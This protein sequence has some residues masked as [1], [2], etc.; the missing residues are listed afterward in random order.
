MGFVAPGRRA[1]KG[2]SFRVFE[3]AL[4]TMARCAYCKTP[5]GHLKDTEACAGCGAPEVRHFNDVAAKLALRLGEDESFMP[6]DGFEKGFSLDSQAY[7]SVRT[8]ARLIRR[9]GQKR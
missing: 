7:H 6:P 8:L 4:E 3:A 1:M 9:V 5:R 2:W